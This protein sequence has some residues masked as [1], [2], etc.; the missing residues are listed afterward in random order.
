LEHLIPHWL[1]PARI[2][3]RIFRRAGDNEMWPVVLIV[4][5]VIIPALCLAWFTG[6]AMRNERLAAQQKLAK[7]YQAQVAAAQTRLNQHWR[8][9]VAELER[10]AGSLSPSAAFA[11]CLA[12]GQVD[13]VVIL[14]PAGR[15]RVRYP[16]LASAAAT[17]FAPLDSLWQEAGRLEQSL[18]PLEA[19]QR[20][21]SLAR[22]TSDS[23]LAARALQSAARCL[24][25]AGRPAEVI[26]LVRQMASD[27]RYRPCLD[28][29]GR[30][31]VPN[32]LLMALEVMTNRASAEFAQM[33]DRLAQRLADYETDGLA[34]AQ[35]RFLMA[36]LAE[37]APDL[38]AFPTLAAER[39]A[40]ELAQ[41][42]SA[43]TTRS[44]WERARV[45]QVW[46]MLSPNGQ[47]LAFIRTERLLA[48]AHAVIGR[49]IVPSDVA[50]RLVPPDGNLPPALVALPAGGFFPGWQLALELED[51]TWLEDAARRQTT[52]YLW[53]A[54]LVVGA[55]AVLGI[56]AVRLMRR[57]MRLA[58]LKNDLA[59]TV[60]HELTTPIA[61]MRVLVETLLDAPAFD[62][63]KTREYLQLIARENHRLGRLI[64]SFLTFSRLER[65]KFI[66]NFTPLAPDQL[67]DAAVESVGDRLD[68]CRCRCEV[69]IEPN[70][71]P[72][73]ADP[74][75][76]TTALVNLLD[77]ACK[78][79][80]ADK[81]ILV[82][83]R[84]GNGTVNFTVKDQGIGIPSHERGRIFQPFYQIDQRLSRRHGGCGLGLSIVQF[85]ATAHHGRVWVESQPGD[86]STF[87]VSLPAARV[88]ATAAQSPAIETSPSCIQ[89]PPRS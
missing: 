62:E 66:F 89:H 24:R 64:Q 85:I 30:L 4:L 12:S 59:A 60:S 25:Q 53:T 37:L 49:E 75:A 41:N 57:Q 16:N 27:E 55:M 58:R 74:D 69:Q 9:T 48:V 14:D 26:A 56:F 82:S 3:R 65:K 1:I 39:L 50:L 7:L 87:T 63:L 70:L 35:R 73:L 2:L 18:H 22:N 79:S 81:S 21:Q 11:R 46:Q 72:V 33:A 88:P 86:G 76:L 44:T 77:N 29:H 32:A 45:P 71:P 23:P 5:A 51:Q 80:D 34:A 6:A 10:L 42:D 54:V 40:V 68:A 15:D 28:P 61:S 13:G 84:A 19:A 36:K 43:P 67:I 78:Y 20:Y 8:E 38:P 17:S 83:A 47:V 31:I 52:I